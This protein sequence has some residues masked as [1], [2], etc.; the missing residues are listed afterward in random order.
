MGPIGVRREELFSFDNQCFSLQG[1][2]GPRLARR[3]AGIL[4]DERR[5][6]QEQIAPLTLS[7]DLKHAE[8]HDYLSW[9]L[10][11]RAGRHGR[12]TVYAPKF[13]G[14]S[15]GPTHLL[16]FMPLMEEMGAVDCAYTG[17]LGG[18]LL[19]LS[20][21]LIN[22]G[23]L[24]RTLE[25]T[26][27]HQFD[28]KPYVVSLA[29]T[30]PSAGT[31]V[32]EWELYP[33]AKII[34]HARRVPG[35]AVLNGRKVF[36]S[37]GHM[38][39][40]HVVVAP[41]DLKDPRSTMGIFMV[42]R[43]AKGFELGRKERKMGQRAGPASELIFED[44]FI[45]KER[46]A[47]DPG[48][49]PEHRGVFKNALNLAL[50][51]S[52]IAVGAWSVGTARAALERAFELATTEKSQ[53]RTLIDQQWAQAI[54]TNMLNNVFAARSVYLEAQFALTLSALGRAR[55]I[56]APEFVGR[57]PVSRLVKMGY[58]LLRLQKMLGSRWFRGQVF[59][60]M[61]A[62]DED[63][64]ARLQ[65]MS[66]MAKVAGSDAAMENC[67]LAVEF[68]GR[69]GLRHDQGLEKVFRDAKLLQIFEGT[70]QLNRL[71]IFD[72]FFARHLPGVK[73]YG[74]VPEAGK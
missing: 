30:E 53:G 51:M 29:I 7:E 74:D 63:G 18:H 39:T 47:H 25:E 17:M 3:V 61:K 5:F 9:E 66:S 59:K 48:D 23:F 16:A 70:N 11:R 58:D 68:L 32:E 19:G 38:A 73:V 40:D 31:D 33:R 45:P 55:A 21:L 42:N 60:R 34:C 54:L 46:I 56:S 27:A 43:E 50:G 52:R 13:L 67:H 15:G 64:M 12:L 22:L 65:Y 36:I 49:F 41:F 14:G 69:A 57:P 6:L 20:V 26:V 10:M 8:D 4:A 2:Y 1:M 72:N 71:N 62:T 24:T 28:E 44:C 35:G 37:T